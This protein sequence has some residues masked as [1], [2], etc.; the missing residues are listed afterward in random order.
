MT[1]VTK[2][3]PGAEGFI[4]SEANGFRSRAEITLSE[5]KA[6]NPGTVLAKITSTE[7]WVE[8]QGEATDGS[9]VA[10]GILCQYTDCTTG[11]KKATAIV[12]DAEVRRD[13]LVW[14]DGMT[15]QYKLD[16]ADDLATV[17]IIVR[18]GPPI[19]SIERQVY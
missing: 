3:E 16:G 2:Q 12:R 15:D 18:D 10:I 5:N 6:C 4:V 1:S 13:D 14:R 17:G 8:Y 19:G 9:Q 11:P 7:A